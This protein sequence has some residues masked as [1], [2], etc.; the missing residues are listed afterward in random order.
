[1]VK[2]NWGSGLV[3]YEV[4]DYFKKSKFLYFIT[5]WI[6]SYLII[7]FRQFSVQTLIY[8]SF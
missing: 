4:A 5:K 6:H 3:G 2:S 1:M 7:Y 8:F